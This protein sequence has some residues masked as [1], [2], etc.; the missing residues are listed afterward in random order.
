[1]TAPPS[2][3]V[4]VTDVRETITNIVH[5]EL[6]REVDPSVDMFDQG[7]TS[8][9]FIRIVAQVNEKYDIAM[10]VAELEEASVDTLSELVARQL[11]SGNR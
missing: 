6:D 1:M 3:D 8:L 7:V 10:D 2:A 5:A 11:K 9:A 4:P